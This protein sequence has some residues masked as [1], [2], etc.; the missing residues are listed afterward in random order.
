MAKHPHT[1]PDRDA[2]AAEHDRVDARAGESP[3]QLAATGPQWPPLTEKA[4][5][6]EFILS[7][8]NGQLSRDN[9][10]LADPVTIVIGQPLK[11]TAPATSTLPATYVPAA[12][13]A[14]CNAL[15][16]YAG[17]S[18]PGVGLQIAV[19]TRNAEVNGKLI[20][21]GAIIT[22]EQALGIANLALT[23]IVVR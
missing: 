12:V 17:T 20:N 23:G 8:A 10:Y 11:K 1:D 19:I 6:A 14:D 21:W 18:Q 13:G 2:Q 16:I 3:E 4:H 22:T 5:S 15:A 9:A 7:E